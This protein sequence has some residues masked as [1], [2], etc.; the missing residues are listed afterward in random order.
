MGTV[1]PVPR[2]LQLYS[3]HMRPFQ[4]RGGY[5]LNAII[6]DLVIW[7]G[8][9]RIWRVCGLLRNGLS[10]WFAT[11]M[12]CRECLA[13]MELSWWRK[14]EGVERIGMMKDAMEPDDG[15]KSGDKVETGPWKF[16]RREVSCWCGFC[17]LRIGRS[18]RI[19]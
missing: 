14:G 19:E 8:C 10:S 16:V 4:R 1:V 6:Q 2:F 13:D 7:L 17:L 5:K 12:A 9:G 11:W 18:T 3:V 15:M